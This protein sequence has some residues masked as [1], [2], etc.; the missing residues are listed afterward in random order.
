[1]LAFG[2]GAV[3][4]CPNV[5]RINGEEQQP[6]CGRRSRPNILYF[7][8]L[9][10]TFPSSRD[11]LAHLKGNSENSSKPELVPDMKFFP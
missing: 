9:W 11:L 10:I 8:T 7:V 2:D 4:S 1:M 5:R 6:S 3:V